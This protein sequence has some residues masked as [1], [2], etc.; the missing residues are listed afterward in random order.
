MES[1]RKHGS[2]SFKGFGWETRWESSDYCVWPRGR[3]YQIGEIAD[4]A[5]MRR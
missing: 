1:Q 3:S 2:E 5:V 4:S